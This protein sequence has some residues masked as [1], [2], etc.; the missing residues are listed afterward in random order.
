MTTALHVAASARLSSAWS[1]SKF[2]LDLVSKI[3][4]L[5]MGDILVN[6]LFEL[7]ALVTQ[8]CPFDS[9]HIIQISS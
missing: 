4:K 5:K 3:C 9:E 7:P 2:L 1:E 8:V 6:I